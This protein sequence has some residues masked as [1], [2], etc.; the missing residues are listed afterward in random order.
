MIQRGRQN[1]ATGKTARQRG[2][3]TARQAKQ[4]DRQNRAAGN[5]A[6]G[7]RQNSATV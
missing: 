5:R 4:R 7:N 2:S 1:G 6:T 3:D